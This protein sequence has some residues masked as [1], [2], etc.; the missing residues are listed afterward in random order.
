MHA[1]FTYAQCTNKNISFK[2]IRV[3]HGCLLSPTHSNSEDKVMVFYAIKMQLQYRCPPIL[4]ARTIS[5][6]PFCEKSYGTLYACHIVKNC[7]QGYMNYYYSKLGT[8]VT[9]KKTYKLQARA[10]QIKMLDIEPSLQG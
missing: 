4:E 8:F 10:S 3:G 6:Q 9:Y 5:A 2:N 7:L 1:Q